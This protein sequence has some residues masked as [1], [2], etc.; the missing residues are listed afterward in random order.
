MLGQ[1]PGP[2]LVA[3][4]LERL[5]ER[6]HKSDA[7][8]AATAGEGG[9]LREETVTRVDGIAS[10][11]PGHAHYLLGVEVGAWAGPGQGRGLVGP[12][13]VQRASV[14]GRVHR[15]RR[16]LQLGRRPGDA[17]RDLAA[18]GN[19]QFQRVSFRGVTRAP[20]SRRARQSGRGR[21]PARRRA[22]RGYVPSTVALGATGAAP[23]PT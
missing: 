21:R 6:P 18:V 16:D 8:L 17:N 9:V 14:V 19:Q 1:S 13:H 23:R 7:R 4:Q 11:S 5:G 10:V 22:P 20:E 15:D 3:Q 12:P 2:D